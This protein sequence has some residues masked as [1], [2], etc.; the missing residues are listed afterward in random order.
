MRPRTI[1][2][3]VCSLLWASV[4]GAQSYSLEHRMDMRITGTLLAAEEQKRDDFVLVNITVQNKPMLLRIGKVE[5][6]TTRGRAQAVKDEVL[7]RQVRFTGPEAL[8]EQLQKP[9]VLGKV[10]TIQGWL[11]TK[12]R[13][14]QVTAVEEVSG[15]TPT[16]KGKED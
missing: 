13:R 10:I 15:A 4:V 16:A 6:L 9:E 7:L 8:M 3:L 12:D 1:I 11:N 5:D 14:F 2:A